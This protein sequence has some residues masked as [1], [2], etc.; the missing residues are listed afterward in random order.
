MM[1]PNRIDCQKLK[2]FHT[3]HPSP[4]S[5][6]LQIVLLQKIPIA[7]QICKKIRLRW[8]FKCALNTIQ[9]SIKIVDFQDKIP[10][11]L[12]IVQFN[13]YFWAFIVTGYWLP[14][15]RVTIQKAFDIN[16]SNKINSEYNVIIQTQN[17]TSDRYFKSRKSLSESKRNFAWLYIIDMFSLKYI[18]YTFMQYETIGIIKYHKAFYSLWNVCVW[19]EGLGEGGGGVECGLLVWANWSGSF[20]WHSTIEL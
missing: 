6:E 4:K 2:I 14:S 11:A 20:F 12:F 10:R 18:T 15:I 1:F 16:F 8:S 19:G 3:F 13:A 7:W 17:E 9:S 5:P